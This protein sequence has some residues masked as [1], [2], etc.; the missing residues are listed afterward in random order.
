MKKKITTLF[1]LALGAVTYAQDGIGIG[2]GTALPHKAA[3]LDIKA[4]QKGVLI[5][6]VEL[7]KTSE[8]GL[9]GLDGVQSMLVYNTKTTEDV[10]PGFY[11]W[12]GGKWELITSQTQL[13]TVVK[14]INE[15]IKEQIEKITNIGGDNDKSFLVSF[16][17]DVPGQQKGLGDLVYLMPIKDGAGKI[18]D[19]TKVE[20]SFADLVK[21]DE[22]KTF[23]K[24]IRKTVKEKV[25]V[26]VKE[27]GKDVE[28]IE[29]KDVE[30][31][32]G[33]IYFGEQ[34][35]IDWIKLDP[36]NNTATNIPDAKGFELDVTSV[37][38][39][40][41]K[42]IFSETETIKT[43]ET[44]IKDTQGVVQVI[45]KGGELQII[46][47]DKDGKDQEIDITKYETKTVLGKGEV[48]TAGTLPAAYVATDKLEAADMKLGEIIYEYKAEGNKTY[49]IN[50]TADIIS[51]FNKNEEIKNTLQDIVKKYLNEGGNVY[52]GEANGKVN[53]LYTMD[54]DGKKTIIDI[55]E[56]II[57]TIITNPEVINTIKEV[58]KV[59]IDK[60]T[61]K[62]VDTGDVI[63]GKKVFKA[64]MKAEV[65]DSA[66]GNYNSNFNANLKPNDFLRLIS[67]DILN[68]DGQLVASS[69]TDVKYAAATGLE[70]KFGVGKMYAP[71]ATGDYEVVLQY[72]ST[73]VY[74]PIAKP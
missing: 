31:V 17:P 62:G 18:T 32:T 56:S 61:E 48:V 59:V 24:E 12:E 4:D 20:I 70:F 46:Y 13:D 35:I 29:E 10:K 51:T 14:T 60:T 57:E 37:V 11:Y 6:R 23:I 52:F 2:I 66:S 43:I 7:K 28:K 72:V 67:I 27:N 33:Y 3:M 1:L 44:I 19:Y 74:T 64:F 16:K 63:D 15:T 26:I 42:N 54:K 69:V 55:K 41:V 34:A 22:T 45:E 50:M 39:N 53:V 71:L 8:W 47:K 30:K 21:G 65:A 58:T 9:T 49:Y 73:E 68:K 38:T 36:T 25:V 40:N 5:P